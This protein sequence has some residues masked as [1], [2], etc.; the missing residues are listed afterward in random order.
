M[1]KLILV[2]IIPALMLFSSCSQRSPYCNITLFSETLNSVFSDEI[3]TESNTFAVKKNDRNAIYC[4]PEKYDN[5][6][7][8][9]YPE[10][11]S[12]II[13]QYNLVFDC[14][15][16]GADAD[17]IKNFTKAVENNNKYIEKTEF[18]AGDYYIIKFKDRRYAAGQ[19]APALKK[20]IDVSDLY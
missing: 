17:F 13:M 12:G 20:N 8:A 11:K 15:K 18:K 4:I 1:K 7:I 6:C 2:L 10:N 9:L 16:S 3:F 19:Q 5:V 14:K